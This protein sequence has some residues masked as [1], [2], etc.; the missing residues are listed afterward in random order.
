MGFL[1]F[2]IGSVRAAPLT[3][4]PIVSPAAVSTPTPAANGNHSEMA[5]ETYV[6][7]AGD[8]LW[9]VALEMGIDVALMPCTVEP[10]FRPEQPLVIG[11]ALQ[12]LPAN[13]WCHT[14]QSGETLTTIAATYGVTVEQIHKV[15]W[16]G[17]TTTPVAAVAL[18]PG[19]HLRIPLQRAISPPESQSSGATG[20]PSFLTWMLNQPVNTS[21]FTVLAVGGSFAEEK[22]LLQRLSERAAQSIKQPGAV[23]ANWPYGSGVFRWPLSG[24]L[25]QGYRYDHRAIDIAAPTGTPIVAAD[26]GVVVRAGWNQQGYGLFVII[27]HNIDYVTLYAHLSEVLVEE[28]Q[29]VAQGDLIGKV[30]STGNS[31]GPHL[32]FEIRDFGRL[33][34]PLELLS[35]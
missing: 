31:T 24:W 25:T 4:A 21:P 30:G 5:P 15:A 12:R 23:P 17:L 3:Q 34:N 35:R 1:L 22:Q 19:Y 10:T 2:A 7:K 20:S 18:T 6:V 27:D 26:R 8:T 9:R 33:T 11:D 29:V 13:Q 28:G 32:H 16:N 14:V